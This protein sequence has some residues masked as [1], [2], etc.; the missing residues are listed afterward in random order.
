M[1]MEMSEELQIGIIIGR[2]LIYNM[3]VDRFWYDISI[4]QLFCCV[5]SSYDFEESLLESVHEQSRIKHYS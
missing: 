2:L 1:L 5:L 4:P 3:T